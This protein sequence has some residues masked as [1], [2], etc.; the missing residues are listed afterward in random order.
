[1]QI[2]SY[3]DNTA[4]RSNGVGSVNRIRSTTSILH[5]RACNHNNILRRVSQLLDDQVD[6][7]P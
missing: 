6:H 5:N 3:I 1:M 2:S 7:L 4:Q